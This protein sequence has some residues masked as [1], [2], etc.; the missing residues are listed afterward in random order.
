MTELVCLLE[1]ASAEEL[2]KTICRKILPPGMQTRFIAFEGKQDL[3]KQVE[4]RLKNWL[5][6][7]SLFLIMR[8][9]DTADCRKIK[10][11]LLKKVAA[12]GKASRSCVRIACHELESFYL[13]DLAAV[14][15]G[16]QLHGL[17]R[18]QNKKKFRQPDS[19]E[20][21]AQELKK[22]TRGVYQKIAGSRAI[23]NCLSLDGTNR[24]RSFNTLIAGLKK[25]TGAQS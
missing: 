24:S 11:N 16:L 18:Q 5:N 2:L 21:P 23:S 25:L 10:Q 14:D 7:D 8:D 1:E 22:L 17:A 13:G 20:N 15:M 9:Q 19:L 6:T 4:K 12:A 3:E